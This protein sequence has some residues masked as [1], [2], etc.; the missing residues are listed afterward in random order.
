MSCDV[1]CDEGF[2]GSPAAFSCTTGT[3]TKPDSNDCAPAPCN[4]TLGDNVEVLGEA[5]CDVEAGDSISDGVSC[6][7]ACADGFTAD[8][9]TTTISCATGSFTTATVVCTAT[10]SGGD[11]DDTPDD[12]TPVDEADEIVSF[13]VHV[14]G[15]NITA[16]AF[17]TAKSEEIVNAFKGAVATVAGVNASQ[18]TIVD[19]S[20]TSSDDTTTVV[21]S[22][23][24]FL[25]ADSDVTST[26]VTSS[27]N[28]TDAIS[29]VLIPAMAVLNITISD[30]MISEIIV[31]D[32]DDGDDGDDTD[33]GDDGDDG[34]EG[35][36]SNSTSNETDNT[37]DDD[38]DATPGSSPASRLVAGI[39]MLLVSFACLD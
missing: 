27:V 1:T 38:A 8:S 36:D 12:S 22:T 32:V 2:V 3:L 30:T 15:E 7:V 17:L 39:S 33:D 35:D 24:I 34:D 6:T 25:P 23:E 13:D 29:D 21:V 19:A 31:A 14:T 26:A 37:T 9:G 28:A 11:S 16:S 4:V 20:E 18:V 10:T 5:A